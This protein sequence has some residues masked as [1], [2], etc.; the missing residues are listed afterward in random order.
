LDDVVADA[1][2]VES[3]GFDSFWLANISGFDALTALAVA[4]ARTQRIELGTFVVPT[5][6]RHPIAMAQQALTTQAATGNRLA[7]GIGLSH[8][9]SMQDRLGFD[10]DHPIRHMREYLSVLNPLLDQQPVTFEGQE[11]RVNGAQLTV[12][13]ASRPSLLVAALGP[14]ML[15]L[16]GKMADGTALWMGGAKYLRDHAVPTISAAAEQAGR[17][18]PRVV[19]ALPFCVTADDA[20]TGRAKEL[21]GRM[22][23]RYGM[24]PSYRAILDREGA[25]TPVDVAVIGTDDEVR[26]RL[27]ELADAGATEFA[28]A[29]F[30]PDRD[31]ARSVDLLQQIRQESPA[32]S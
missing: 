2:R 25:E 19:A 31:T 27:A 6:P 9:V 7:L 1:E 32:S 23:E 15:K 26:Q 20:E 21:C 12:P 17:S 10:W 14:Q 24:L 4:G 11:F 30:S 29:L 3:Q 13:G 5:F 8:R 22:F 28:A 16:T 18:V